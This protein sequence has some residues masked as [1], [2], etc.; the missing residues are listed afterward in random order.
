MSENSY[1][2]IGE[3]NAQ[4]DAQTS[5]K[6]LTPDEFA[7]LVG[8]QRQTISYH[9]RQGLLLRWVEKG[10]IKTEPYQIPHSLVEWFLAQKGI[11]TRAKSSKISAPPPQVYSPTPAQVTQISPQADAKISESFAIMLEQIKDSHKDAMAAKDETIRELR[12][13]IEKLEE[14]KA[15]M[16]RQIEAGNTAMITMKEARKIR[17]EA[18]KSFWDFFK[19]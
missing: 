11:G 19:K 9:L 14:D 1:A 2:P 15:V 8:V 5:E 12:E 10:E 17:E 18:S 13:R 7:D 6:P 4:V 3:S 16:T